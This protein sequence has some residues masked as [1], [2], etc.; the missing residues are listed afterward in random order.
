MTSFSTIVES[1]PELFVNFF[2]GN[3]LCCCQI[4]IKYH[5][6]ARGNGLTEKNITMIIITRKIGYGPQLKD[7]TRTKDLIVT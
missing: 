3:I 6:E 4:K 1:L 2:V 5:N 7:F